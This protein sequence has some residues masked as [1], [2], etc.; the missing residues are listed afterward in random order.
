[1]R[2]S[3]KNE[4]ILMAE[5]LSLWRCERFQSCRYRNYWTLVFISQIACKKSASIQTIT[6]RPNF[7]GCHTENTT[8]FFF[9]FGPTQTAEPS[10]LPSSERPGQR[11]VRAR[12]SSRS[13]WARAVEPAPCW[14]GRLA[15]LRSAR[16]LPRADTPRSKAL[17]WS[18]AVDEV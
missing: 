12:C 14:G 15:R 2:T 18:W 9:Q 8:I 16:I 4:E 6:D 13:V 17:E 11:L 1:M 7:G 5:N 3:P 10:E